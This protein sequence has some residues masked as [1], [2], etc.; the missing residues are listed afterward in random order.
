M[1][2]VIVAIVMEIA[3]MDCMGMEHAYAM[4]VLIVSSDVEIVSVDD[5]ERTAMNS[6]PGKRVFVG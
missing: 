2:H 1:K 6:V 3:W 5:L 4:T